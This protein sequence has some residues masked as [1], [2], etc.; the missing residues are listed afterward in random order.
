MLLGLFGCAGS[1]PP[2]SSEATGSAV[3]SRA[4]PSKRALGDLVPLK[5]FVGTLPPSVSC[6]APCAPGEES[7]RVGGSCLC[8]ADVRSLTSQVPAPDRW[9]VARGE[10]LVEAERS[11]LKACGEAPLEER[12]SREAPLGCPWS[13]RELLVVYGTPERAASRR[14]GPYRGHRPRPQSSRRKLTQSYLRIADEKTAPS[15]PPITDGRARQA[16]TPRVQSAKK[17]NTTA[18]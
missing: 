4:L 10:S 9:F 8:A 13:G 1:S 5:D 6:G 17:S 15:R 7:L 12:S 3:E 2:R 11:P 16:P 14:P 18:R